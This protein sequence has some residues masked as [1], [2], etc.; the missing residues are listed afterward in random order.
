MQLKRRQFL[1]LSAM[2]TGAAVMAACGSTPAP[3]AVPV[4]AT[5][6]PT[7]AAV[8]TAT[9]A[10][11]AAPTPTATTVAAE[12]SGKYKDAPMLADM[13]AAGTLPPVDERLP[14][15]PKVCE[16]TDSIGQY[17]GR[18]TIA[19]SGAWMLGG[20]YGV[21]PLVTYARDNVAIEPNLAERWEISD[22]GKEFTFYLR[23]GV[24]WSDGEP[25]DANDIMFWYEDVLLN[26]EMS[27]SV[28]KWLTPGGELGKLEK[29]DDYT[30]KFSFA[31]PFGSFLD[32][33]AFNGA[34][35]TNYARHY[36]EQFHINYADKDELAK[37]TADGGF[38]QWFQLLGSKNSYDRNPDL[39]VLR[40]WQ[41]VNKDW[42]TQA[43]ASR[44]PFYWKVDPEG[45]QLPYL[46]EI[47]WIIVADAEMIPMRLVTGEVNHQAWSTGIKNYTLYM[48]NRE[49]GGYDVS[50]WDY[51]GSGTSM[52]VNQAKMIDAADADQK[53]IYD[54]LKNRDFRIGLSKAMDRDD[55]NNLVYQGLSEPAIEVFPESVKSD[56]E[57][58]ALYEYNVDDANAI[59]DSV[60]LTERDGEGYRLTAAGKPLDLVMIGLPMYAIHQD[61][62]QVIVEYW[63]EVGVKCTMDWIAIELWWPRV[64][65]GD[66]DIVGYESDY[67]AGNLFRI[68]YPRPVFP[69]EPST[70]WAGAWGAW[71]STDGKQGVEPDD[72]D[73]KKLQDLYGQI[74]QE[75]DPTKSRA[76]LDESFAIVAKN[77]WPIHTVANRP[78]PNIVAK[79]FKN[80]PEWGTD[81]WPVLGERTTKPEQY[82]IEQA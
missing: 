53:E 74:L 36:F 59:L 43:T 4:E 11:A 61:V 15:N 71:Y 1:Q 78:E 72:A 76:M 6:A 34:W 73:A 30:I 2:A 67:S 7:A 41:I 10:A 79:N 49:K 22:D 56:P 77:L 25:W 51:G 63:K 27:P 66:Y 14:M 29:I 64:A 44:N 21:E 57:I 46:D 28:P 52:H 38:E 19:D 18:W 13:V 81:W 24:K 62:A 82:W 42:T 8:P 39:P 60:G 69:V 26:E 12:T 23:Q 3:T 35:L 80:V 48:E 54:L 5:T 32:Q 75:P 40:A 33:L 70:Y 68:T 50:I 55:I 20:H 9:T 37:L 31:V 45:N 65:E 58:Q 17:G 16:V 47:S